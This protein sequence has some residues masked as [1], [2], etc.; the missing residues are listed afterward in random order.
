MAADP[1]NIAFVF[2][3]GRGANL[4]GYRSAAFRGALAQE[5]IAPVVIDVVDPESAVVSAGPDSLSCREAGFPDVLRAAAPAL[6]QTFGPEAELGPVWRAAAHAGRPVLHFVQTAPAGPNGR[7]GA[8][9]RGL[10]AL[11]Q[12]FSP[13]RHVSGVLGASRTA[14]SHALAA[15]CF[16]AATFSRVIA[17]PIELPTQRTSA[18]ERSA[19]PTFG[20]Y[21]PSAGEENV[22]FILQAVALTGHP[23]LFKVRLASPSYQL[24]PILPRNVD[25]A[26]PADPQDFLASVDALILPHDADHLLAILM[27]ALRDGKNVIVPDGGAACELTGAGRHGVLFTPGSAYDL[28]LKINLL[29]HLSAD[30]PFQFRAGEEAAR[31]CAP[32]EIAKAFAA[33][34]RFALASVRG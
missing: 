31:K 16:P 5:G 29:T 34:F 27:L 33:A 18:S 32:G 17:P 1:L 4:S 6:V 23:N 21:D 9:M 2:R 7:R 20:V 15:G 24:P 19:V 14:V 13:S 11:A 30:P 28:A 12:K 26:V 3:P 8:L 22:R 25:A 10:S